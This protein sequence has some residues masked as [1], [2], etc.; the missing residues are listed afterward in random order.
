MIRRLLLELQVDDF[1][2]MKGKYIWVLGEEEGLS[3]TPK[4][5]QRL[6]VDGGSNSKP[7]IFQEVFDQFK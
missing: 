1:S 5:I 2:E 7:L 3:F 6:S 4:G